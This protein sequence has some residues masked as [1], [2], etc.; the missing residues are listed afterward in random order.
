MLLIVFLEMQKNILKCQTG[1]LKTRKN[2]RVIN[3]LKID[4]ILSK[5]EEEM[6]EDGRRWKKIRETCPTPCTNETVM[7]KTQGMNKNFI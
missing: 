7:F 1:N 2:D 4:S 3:F 6:E 5:E